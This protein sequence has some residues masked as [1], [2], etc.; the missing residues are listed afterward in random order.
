[1]N[2]NPASI[3]WRRSSD[4]AKAVRATAGVRPPCSG[5]SPQPPDQLVS[6]HVRHADVHDHHGGLCHGTQAR[7]SAPER[8]AVTFAPRSSMIR[9][10]R[11]MA[12]A[13]SSTT[14]TAMPLR[15]GV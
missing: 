4:R 10:T 14:I 1:M 13:S 8:Q 11:S 9:L 5:L 6:I 15:S 2:V 7:H 3:A 12:S